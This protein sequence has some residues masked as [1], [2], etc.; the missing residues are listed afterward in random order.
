MR[1]EI[2]GLE[3]DIDR[4]G[5]TIAVSLAATRNGDR[6]ALG[7]WYLNDGEDFVAAR[8]GAHELRGAGLAAE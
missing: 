7:H 4:D 5:E 3:I 1:I 8:V 2:D 6:R